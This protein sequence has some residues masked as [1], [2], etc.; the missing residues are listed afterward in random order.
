MAMAG[1]LY[2]YDSWRQLGQ[3]PPR[4]VAEVWDDYLAMIESVPENRRH[5]RV[6]AGHNC[7]VLPEEERFVTPALIENTCLVGTADQIAERLHG[8]D[9]AGLDE[10]VILPALAPR[11]DVI[12]R[13]A[14]EVLP[15]LAGA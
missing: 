9:A 13:V 12:E 5:Q 3:R 7:W 6:H 14:R 1:L 2:A 10:I 4:A 8:Y 11:Y 15:A